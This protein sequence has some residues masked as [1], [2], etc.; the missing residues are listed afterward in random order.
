ML[1]QLLYELSNERISLSK[2][3]TQSKI[4]ASQI[5]EQTIQIWISKEIDGYDFNDDLLPLYRKIP[6]RTCVTFQLPYRKSETQAIETTEEDKLADLLNLHVVQ[7]PIA[8]IEHNI[9]E[10]KTTMGNIPLTPDLLRLLDKLYGQDIRQ[11]GGVMHSAHFEIAKIHLV[12]IINRTKQR[13]IDNL[14]FLQDKYP[15]LKNQFM[16]EQNN[17]QHVSNTITNYIH[18]HNSPVTIASG[19]TVIQKDIQVML[20]EINYSELEKLGVT[21]SQVAELKEIAVLHKD[22]KPTLKSKIGKWVGTVATSLVTQGL[23]KN[24]PQISEFIQKHFH[25]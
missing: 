21:N 3:L 7:S 23:T 19:H 1:T 8:I 16:T 25:V 20:S 2:A 13:L 14:I 18:G 10:L 11:R 15:E 12:D 9:D 5:N 17:E 6:C 24:L 22:D 4:I